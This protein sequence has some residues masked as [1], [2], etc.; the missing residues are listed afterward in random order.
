MI[1]KTDN[2]FRVLSLNK[3]FPT[4]QNTPAGKMNLRIWKVSL[5]SNKVSV[6]QVF[7]QGFY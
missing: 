1:F 7:K 5:I 6:K 4:N 3:T 2:C